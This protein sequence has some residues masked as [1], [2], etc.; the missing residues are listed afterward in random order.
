[1]SRVGVGLASVVLCLALA[2]PA[3]AQST[4]NGLYEPFPA[5]A[6]RARAQHFVN[7]L[8]AHS[9]PVSTAQLAHGS[10][11]GGTL[12]PTATG[13]A[14]AR[15]SGDAGPSASVGWVLAVALLAVCAAPALRAAAVRR[16]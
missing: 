9:P 5:A 2:A 3:G 7:R 12:G 4:G 15:A 8:R 6:S 10:F 14:S 1:M 16:G 13:A 11:V